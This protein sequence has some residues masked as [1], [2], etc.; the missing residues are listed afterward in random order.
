MKIS[1]TPQCWG[2]PGV[3]RY[4]IEVNHKAVCSSRYTSSPECPFV[5]WGGGWQVNNNTQLKKVTK[6]S[7]LLTDST[8]IRLDLLLPQDKRTLFRVRK[9]FATVC[10]LSDPGKLPLLNSLPLHQLNFITSGF[11]QNNLKWTSSTSH[12]NPLIVNC[13]YCQ[14]TQRTPLKSLT[15]KLS[16][17]SRHKYSFTVNGN[18]NS[19]TIIFNTI[20]KTM[21][22]VLS[23][24]SGFP[25]ELAQNTNF[26]ST[27]I[28]IQL[29]TVV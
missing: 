18:C 20:F 6:P 17:L 28:D 26:S 2:T 4:K 24:L 15:V 9:L 5:L 12:S 21:P 13:L 19:N 29:L 7:N 22:E 11:K 14:T 25:T 3:L 1:V 8:A 23:R 10:Q 27:T 16:K